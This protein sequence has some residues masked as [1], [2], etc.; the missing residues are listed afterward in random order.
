MWNNVG[1]GVGTGLSSFHNHH[2]VGNV[3]N[4]GGLNHA[5]V[6]HNNHRGYYGNNFRSNRLFYGLGTGFW[7]YYAW[8]Y[9][10]IWGGYSG[11]GGF[12]SGW[13]L[14]IG[15]SWGYGLGGY[16]LGGY[17]L[18]GYGLGGYGLGGW[19]LGRSGYGLGGY[20]LGG[21]GG[22]G[23]YGYGGNGGYGYNSSCVYNPGY[24]GYSNGYSYVANST[25]YYGYGNA[26]LTTAY[27]VGGTAPATGPVQVQVAQIDADPAPIVRAQSTDDNLDFGA[28][29]EAEFKAGNY[30]KSVKMWKHAILDEPK[31]GVLVMML[32]QGLF[33]SGKFDE[34]A[35]ATQ[36]GMLLLKE[37]DWGV[38]V[39]NYRELYSKVGDYT[40]QLRLLE[41][42]RKDKPEDP[43]LR[44]ILGFHYGYLG[45][46]TEAVRELDKAATLAPQDELASRLKQV[47]EAKLQKASGKTPTLA[48]PAP[49]GIPKKSD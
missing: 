4:V 8:N 34:A 5:G 22:Y 25:G 15:N 32:A 44:F 36:Q 37:E 40:T 12:G 30:E 43:G 13:G 17:G 39:S 48:P 46:P 35:G 3:G 28:A 23:G 49:Q 38:V 42:A 45:F 47:V 20:G 2:H 19:G 21:Y 6:G 24:S 9:R 1:R 7:P 18:G 33:A 26:P 27:A 10:P 16:G 11:Y 31:N 29:G 41:K 14:G